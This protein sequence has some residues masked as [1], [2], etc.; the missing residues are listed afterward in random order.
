MALDIRN[1]TVHSRGR[2]VRLTAVEFTVL[3]LLLQRAGSVVSREELVRAALQRSFTPAD[4]S[5]DMHVS[6]LRKK[7]GEPG[8]S[9]EYIKTV[10]GAGYVYR[11]AAASAST[12]LPLPMK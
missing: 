5:I 11:A 1:R 12:R 7:L 10:R 3:E 9:S 8:K 6:N 4:R 2:S